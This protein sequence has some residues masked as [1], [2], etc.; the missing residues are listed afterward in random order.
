MKTVKQNGG[1]L[2]IFKLLNYLVIIHKFEP[3]REKINFVRVQFF[4]LR[5]DLIPFLTR[6]AVCSAIGKAMSTSW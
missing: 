5:L 3:I 4:F 2:R 1:M 6:D